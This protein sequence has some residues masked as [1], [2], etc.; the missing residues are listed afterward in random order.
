VFDAAKEK[1][2]KDTYVDTSHGLNPEIA[3]KF[4]KPIGTVTVRQGESFYVYRI[5][6]R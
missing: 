2:G 5:P 1:W 4:G 6:L 3:K